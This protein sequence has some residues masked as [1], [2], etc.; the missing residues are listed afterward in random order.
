QNTALGQITI[1][2]ATDVTLQSVL[3]TG[4]KQEAGTGLTTLAGPVTTTGVAGI[5]L[6]GKDLRIEKLVTT[7]NDGVVTTNHTDAVTILADG[8]IQS[9]GSVNISAASI[10]TA[11]DIQTS[12]DDITLT[13]ATTLTGSITLGTGAGGGDI[14]LNSS[15]EG[16]AD[17]AQNLTIAAGTGNVTLVTAAGQTTALGQVTIQSAK[18]VTLQSVRATGLKQDTGT[19]LTTLSGPIITTGVAGI[20]LKGTDLRVEKLVTTLNDGG[21]T[22]NHSGAITILNDGDIQSAGNVNISAGSIATSGDIQTSDDDITLTG[23]ATLTG[24]ITLDTGAGAGNVT[25]NGSVDGTAAGS[26]TL[27]FVAGTGNVI[28]LAATGQN[29]ALGQITIQSATNVNLQGIRATGLKQEA[30]SGITALTGPVTTTGPAGIDLKGKDL[31]VEKLIVTQNNGGVLIDNSGTVTMLAAGDIQSDGSVS[32]SASSISTAGDIITSGDSVTL[33]DAVVLTGPV[34]IGTAGSTAGNIFF[35]AGVDLSG[36]DLRL[37]SGDQG[38]ITAEQAITGDGSLIVE[39]GLSMTFNQ[40]SLRRL[41]ILRAVAS[42]HFTAAVT[43]SSNGPGTPPVA[44]RVRSLGNVDIDGTVTANASG[45]L[46]IDVAGV[47]ININ[48]DMQATGSISVRASRDLSVAAVTVTADSDANGGVLRLRGDDDL[49]NGGM[50]QAAAGSVLKGASVD[51]AAAEIL[52]HTVTAASGDVLIVSGGSATLNNTV[53]S[54]TGAVVVRAASNLAIAGDLSAALHAELRADTDLNG[55]GAISQTAG[56]VTAASGV[57]SAAAGID[58]VGEPGLPAGFTVSLGNVSAINRVSGNLR[59]VQTAAGGTLTTGLIRN[60]PGPVVLRVLNGSLADG[61][62]ADR[63]IEAAFAD[64][65]VTGG[66]IGSAS[67]DVFRGIFDAIEVDISGAFVVSAPDGFAVVSGHMGGP[68]SVTAASAYL[69]SAGDIDLS[70]NAPVINANL[71]VLSGGIVRTPDAGLAVTGDLR[72][73]ANSVSSQTLSNPVVLGTPA[74]RTDRLLLK[75]TSSSATD[76]Q[77]E[78][79]QLDAA[80]ESTLQLTLHGPTLFTD[81]NCDLT[82]LNNPGQLTVLQSAASSVT[83]G[84]S[85]GTSAGSS[86]NDR[87]ISGGLLLVG[88]SSFILDHPENNVGVLAAEI[89]G[90]LTY[91]DTNTL[92]I[93]QLTGG[94]SGLSAIGVSTLDKEILISTESGNLELLRRVSAGTAKVGLSAGGDL[95]QNVTTRV[96]AAEAILRAGGNISLASPHNDIGRIA[97]TSGQNAE[98]QMAGGLTVGAVTLSSG[99]LSGVVSG[100]FTDLRALSGNLLLERSVTAGSGALLEASGSVAQLAGA[101]LQSAGLAVKAGSFVDLQDNGNAIGTFAADSGGTLRLNHASALDISTVTVNGVTLT[102][103]TT[104]GADGLLTTLSGGIQLSRAVNLGAGNLGLFSASTVQQGTA[105]DITAQGLAVRATGAILLDN[106]GNLIARLAMTGD[107]DATVRSGQS[108]RV[109]TVNVTGV[110]TTGIVLTSG[111]L[112]IRTTAGSLEISNSVS[113]T[114][115]TSTASLFSAADVDLNADVAAPASLTIVADADNSGSGA[116]RGSGLLSTAVGRLEAAEGIGTLAPIQTK[117]NLVSARNTGGGSIRLSEVSAG[118]DLAIADVENSAGLVDITVNSGGLL[119][120]NADTLNI[121]ARLVTLTAVGGNIGTSWSPFF[122]QQPDTIEVNVAESLLAVASG[123]TVALS[124]LIGGEITG[125]ANAFYVSSTESLTFLSDT[126]AIANLALL[127]DSDKSGSGILTLA[128]SLTVSDNLFLTGAQIVAADGTI[129]LAA[130]R[131]LVRTGSN[132]SLNVALSETAAGRPGV[133]DVSAHG[134]LIIELGT[135]AVLADLDGDNVALKTTDAAGSITVNAAGTTLTVADDVI[136]NLDSQSTA[137]TGQIS[138][139]A[140]TLLIQDAI[141]ADNGDVALRAFAAVHFEDTVS[142]ADDFDLNGTLDNDNL[143]AVSTLSGNVKVLAGSFA[144]NGATAGE[145]QMAGA[146]RLIAG[147]TDNPISPGSNGN[148]NFSPI[149][150]GTQTKPAGSA[151][152]RLAADLNISLSGLF[153]VSE[154]TDAIVVESATGAILSTAS[155]GA[156]AIS[157]LSDNGTA[158]LLS[159]GSIGATTASIELHVSRIL[160]VS[161]T[162]SMFLIEQNGLL[163][164]DLQAASGDVHITLLDGSLLDGDA[165]VDVVAVNTT[166]QL[167]GTNTT[168]GTAANALQTSVNTLSVQNSGQQYLVELNGLSGVNLNAT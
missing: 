167:N 26:Q 52:L 82:A 31:R 55:T 20:D 103:L 71:A 145:I 65:S 77:I 84:T 57:F 102:G 136:S 73:E 64:I 134:D 66:S 154:G 27:T 143:L 74:K 123:Y 25:L 158:Q 49:Q 15:I 163:A 48:R 1:Q 117:M 75:V 5:D 16:S 101:S 11:G 6:K 168:V 148:N 60:V 34:L 81:L 116:I 139:S 21:V 4:L 8:D 30:G 104:A 100:G 54:T 141:L 51:L 160:A 83:Q 86:M 19:G 106:P 63:N 13:G 96:H 155:P 93:S 3:A 2:S 166:I 43:V 61:N 153:S 46:G 149:E 28:L 151:S 122:L 56:I 110:S 68:V 80:A 29:T 10:K 78:A 165:A 38:S 76:F 118:G 42:V 115:A 126:P 99:S 152:I 98:A 41:D 79:D 94:P 142:S 23:A 18:N 124:G 44:F 112:T 108:L 92:Q 121:R 67:G 114:S 62:G 128:N 47:D 125:A 135:S 50:L 88:S 162:G 87:L 156:A 129:D 97:L 32:I 17:G 150:P 146:T 69:Q 12:D 95:T 161:Q 91:R 138:L 159:R 36:H 7:Q 140:S 107:D 147:R 89:G 37:N 14:L 90:N 40:L 130:K 22:T 133:L 53:K 131:L 105:G 45:G 157:L 111:D 72:L 39:N 24:S 119:D 58:G 70:A 164:I 132:V 137:G 120:G 109:A 33:D 144:V 9:A 59:I 113:I 127:A 85:R 35:R